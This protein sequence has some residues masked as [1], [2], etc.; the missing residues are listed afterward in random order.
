MIHNKLTALLCAL[1]LC[2]LPL[3]GLA[4]SPEDAAVPG[5]FPERGVILPMTQEDLDMGLL[6]S[7]NVVSTT[8]VSQLPIFDILYS[9]AQSNAAVMS[10]YTEE[11]LEDEETFWMFVY[12]LMSNNY[13]LFEVA[14]FETEY[15]QKKADSGIAPADLTGIDTAY[16]LGENDGY[17]YIAIDTAALNTYSSEDVK[18]RALA[19]SARAKELLDGMTFQ[20]I[21]F[22]PGEIATVPHAFPAFSTQDLHGNTVTNEIF[23]GKDLTVVNVWGTFCTPCINEMPDLAEWSASM[24]ENVQLIGLVSDLY[25]ADD[26]ETLELAL[27]ICEATGAS[28]PSLIAGDDFMSL[29]SGV[30][31]VPTTFF[32]D[33]SGAIVGEPIVG[34]NVPGCKAFVEEYLHAL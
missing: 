25:S 9:D 21:A 24:P 23:S 26:A 22:A 28:Y 11:A 33:G 29:L 19:A 8:E 2:I 5:N 20:K 18:E 6:L 10:R 1:L 17:T 15:Y 7:R 12:E 4:E 32:V 30:V 13:P 34:A 31:G 27:A 14:L 16:V 3:S